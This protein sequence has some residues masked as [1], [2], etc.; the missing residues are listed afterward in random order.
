MLGNIEFATE[1]NWLNFVT[2]RLVCKSQLAISI[3]VTPQSLW[4]LIIWEFTVHTCFAV[5]CV[6][7]FVLG[8]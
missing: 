4:S 1:V 3:I 6:G 7:Q 2:F 5:Q 8:A